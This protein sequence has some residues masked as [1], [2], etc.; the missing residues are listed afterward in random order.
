MIGDKFWDFRFKDLVCSMYNYFFNLNVKKIYEKYGI[1][2]KIFLGFNDKKN[3][4]FYMY[5]DW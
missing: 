2:W 4:V 5:I 3:Y 1:I